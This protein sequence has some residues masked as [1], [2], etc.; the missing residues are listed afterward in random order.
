MVIQTFSLICAAVLINSCSDPVPTFSSTSPGANI[1]V[2]R[3]TPDIFK[4]YNRTGNATMA[5]SWTRNID[6]SGIAFDHKK[7]LTL[8][9]PRHVVMAKH[10]KRPTGSKAVFHGRGGEF[11]ERTLIKVVN[12]ASDIS[13]GLLDSPLPAAYRSYALPRAS[14]DLAGGIVG[15]PVY[16]TDQN[17]RIF[18]HRIAGIRGP[19]I[20][21][22][23]PPER[24][25]GYSKNLVSGDSGNPSFILNRGQPVLIETHTTGGPGAG[26]YY[27]HPI[28]QESIRNAVRTLDPN[29]QIRTV[30]ID[31]REGAP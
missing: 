20:V 19:M 8:I 2:M 29:Y 15:W 31:L 10:Y 12:A 4:Q 26:P 23:H 5:K 1:A 28:I 21:F 18:V 16:L 17:R 25:A 13:V 6:T 22:R 11:A 27:G 24:A 30:P 7:T 14:A 9:T 3:A